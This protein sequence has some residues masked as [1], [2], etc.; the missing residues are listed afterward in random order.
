[1]AAT[2]LQYVAITQFAGHDYHLLLDIWLHVVPAL[3]VFW[4]LSY[5]RYNQLAYI[6]RLPLLLLL[7]WSIPVLVVIHPLAKSDPILEGVYA[8]CIAIWIM[9]GCIEVYRNRR[10]K[11]KELIGGL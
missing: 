3:P 2:L 7:V 10:N 9:A 6:K 8:G 1:M 4:L 5:I 11:T